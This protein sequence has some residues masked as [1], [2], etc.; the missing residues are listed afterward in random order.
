M[1]LLACACAACGFG[2]RADEVTGYSLAL[3]RDSSALRIDGA[4]VAT[5]R[6]R[7]GIRI[8][9]TYPTRTQLGLT[10]G[11][12]F[13]TQPRYPTVAGTDGGGYFLRLDADQPV[14]ATSTVRAS[15]HGAYQFE[16]IYS[17]DDDEDAVRLHAFIAGVGLSGAV[18]SW[19]RVGLRADVGTINGVQS[20]DAL[21]PARRDV[22]WNEE[23]G[24]GASIEFNV[25]QG[26]YVG[27]R[28]GTGIDRG[29]ALYF[30][31]RI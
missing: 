21:N 2:A 9:E 18:A 30:E 27:L 5:I 10:L 23:F 25:E 26:G 29:F 31:R 17:G 6:E 16:Q 1:H 4:A 12:V 11:Q 14:Y 28:G 13:F 7:V 24:A 22:E 19:I 20:T 8:E 15:I 3:E